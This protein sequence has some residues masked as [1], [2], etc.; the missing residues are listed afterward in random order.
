M[1]KNILF[2]I[3]LVFLSSFI[4]A[5][6][7]DFQQYTKQDGL[8]QSVII[9]SFQDSYGFLWFG[10]QNGLN[11]FDG[12]EFKTFLHDPFDSTTIS[13]NWIF[14]IIEDNNSDLW[15]G[16]KDGLNK[17]NRKTGKFE[18]ILYKSK[19]ETESKD[20][21]Y[22]LFKTQ[23]G[24][25]LINDE[26]FF[27]RYNSEKNEFKRYQNKLCNDFSVKDFT[28]PI[29]EDRNGFIWIAT[30]Q[31]LAK[32]NPE[33]N[34]FKNFTI[35][36][37]KIG[38]NFIYSIFE[39][40]NGTILFGTENGLEKYNA[41][42]ENFT[43]INYS[44]YIT[45]G[46]NTIYSITQ[47]AKNNYWI[48]TNNGLLKM[49]VLKSGKLK[50]SDFTTQNSFL[51][52]NIV[53]S[54]LID[55][56]ENLW[57]GTLKELS[58]ADLKPKKFKLYQRN[59]TSESV[60]FLDNL[61]ASI[62]KQNDSIIWVGNWGKGLN[63][64]NRNSG[65]IEYYSTEQTG[66][67][68]ILNDFVHCIFKNNLGD[69]WIGTRDGLLAYNP[70][71][72]LFIRLNIFYDN[73]KILNLENQRILTIIQDFENNY[74]IATDHGVYHF[75]ENI[76]PIENFTSENETNKITGNLIYDLLEDSNHNIWFASSTG[77]NKYDRNTKTITQIIRNDKEDNTLCDN[78][79]VSLCEDNIG[80]IWI[81]TQS[82][83]NYYNPNE[84]TFEHFSTH[85]GLPDKLIYEILMDKNN[86]IW[87]AT[88]FGL[89]RLDSKSHEFVNYS[90]FD[91]I[92]SVE[93]NLNA[94]YKS[95]DGE[96]FL[97]GMNGVNSFYPDSIFFNRNIP[98]IQFTDFIVKNSDGDRYI[99]VTTTN[100][101]KLSRKDYEFTVKF[102]AL[103]FTFPQLNQYAY[104]M[105]GINE[106]WVEIKE[107]NFVTFSNLPPGEYT[108]VVKGS[109]NDGTWNE[110]GK[111]L[112][113]IIKPPFW[114][115]TLAFIFYAI[116]LVVIIYLVIKFRERNLIREREIL[117]EKVVERTAII[118][119]QKA[120]IEKAHTEI[121]DSIS[122]A[123]KIQ[124][125]L[126]PHQ[127]NLKNIFSEYLLI[128][129]PKHTVSGDFF[130]TKEINNFKVFLVADCTGHGVPGAFLSMLG[131]SL[132][133]DIIPRQEITNA[134]Q[135]LEL[136]RTMVKEVLQQSDIF[137]L[138]QDGL[139]LALCIYN[140][141]TNQLQ[142]S[143]ANSSMILV[144]DK[145]KFNTQK[146]IENPDKMRIFETDNSSKI[147]VEFLP[148]NNPIGIFVKEVPFRDCFIEH[149]E[150]NVYYLF[151]DGYAD[152]FSETHQKYTKTRF[153]TLIINNSNLPLKEQQVN[154]EKEL[155]NWKGNTRQIDDILILAV[156]I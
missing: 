154:F 20:I 57:A 88:G 45:S 29:I 156:K 38:G 43:H 105:I 124:A 109:N 62:Y 139:D 95:P 151:S 14:S 40:N 9:C 78:F 120:K 126:L 63:I 50:F 141:D 128:Y 46:D 153:K 30:T 51:S 16:T 65:E 39:D 59:N 121:T 15:I 113:I 6:N 22:G 125:A 87:F 150:D 34:Y 145:D 18:R 81:G 97:G 13:N 143:G 1:F 133:N 54:L 41:E 69:I 48:G 100:E 140:T 152:Q 37:K 44:D 89:A 137:V 132:L 119:E 134:S 76:I 107:R 42:T 58:K 108:L 115:T 31:G 103:D 106:D 24:D 47:D 96:I 117:E 49:N 94:V 118:Q 104:K 3:Y 56:T 80:N 148:T 82:G 52:H 131:V 71:Q 130:Y 110:E 98:I 66:K 2:S 73:N 64:F 144:K 116:L 26:L 10:T 136:M 112:K 127:D 123:A 91:G 146:A 27:Y 122:Y 33:N 35:E 135:I 111:S 79:V 92:Q 5:Q 25:I 36:N 85:N 4:F 114:Q 101:V 55:K 28:L 74:W 60:D 99:S 75:D 61:I 53:Y 11:R 23:N 90:L 142:Y 68:H 86:D 72:K 149:E 129:L 12:Y 77:L 67:N 84:N 8:S 83:A 21:T 147:L 70:E 32:Y 19:V 138:T 155:A 7:I 102:A 17:L 93:F